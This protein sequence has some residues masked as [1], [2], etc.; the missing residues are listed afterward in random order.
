MSQLQ[1]INLT[2]GLV[3]VLAIIYFALL[4]I[5]NDAITITEDMAGWDCHTMGN[6]ICGVGA[7]HH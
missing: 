1:T 7:Q 3:I 2:L 6:R 5:T 4:G